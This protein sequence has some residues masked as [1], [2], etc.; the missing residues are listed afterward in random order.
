MKLNRAR[1]HL[2]EI[3][4]ACD[5]FVRDDPDTAAGV[6]VK[7]DNDAGQFTLYAI[8]PQEFPLEMS[9]PVGDALHNLRS[10]LDNLA[11]QLVIAA[12]NTPGKHTEFPIFEDEG[13]FNAKA[14]RKTRGMSP[15][16]LAAIRSLQPFVAWPEH[17]QHATMWKIHELTNIDKHRLPHIVC[18][19]LARVH[20]VVECPTDCAA[21][22][23]YMAPQ[24]PLRHDAV[25]LDVR[26]DPLRATALP[27]DAKMNVEFNVSLDVA[28]ENPETEF[29]SAGLEPLPGTPIQ[30][31]LN[32][33]LDH[34]ESAVLP[35]FAGEF[36]P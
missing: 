1:K 19:W 32:V 9:A 30:H 23:V 18:L 7:R 15:S 3:E 10:A 2:Q 8:I 17:P 13:E 28:I 21:K 31:F 24:G 26:W 6:R 20:G 29:L 14:P 16:A 4:A 5:R 12:G 22:V 35:A 34:L 25:I 33:A 27:P 11:W 36:S